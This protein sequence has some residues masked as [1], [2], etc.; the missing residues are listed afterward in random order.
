VAPQVLVA[1]VLLNLHRSAVDI[2]YLWMMFRRRKLD[3]PWTRVTVCDSHWFVCLWPQI[4]HVVEKFRD[5]GK[6]EVS[7][8]FRINWN[9][10]SQTFVFAVVRFSKCK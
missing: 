4:M 6:V 5:V 10:F 1:R 9:I 3:D 8:W 7:T 2:P